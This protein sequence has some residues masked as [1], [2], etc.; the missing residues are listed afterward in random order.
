MKLMNGFPRPNPLVL[1]VFLIL[2]AHKHFMLYCWKLNE[3]N[4]GMI[5]NGIDDNDDD[6]AKGW[7]LRKIPRPLLY[8]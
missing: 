6:D 1:L 4:A 3:S 7:K 2:L 8:C 5:S